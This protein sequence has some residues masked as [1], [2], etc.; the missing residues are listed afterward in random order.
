M[1]T[2]TQHLRGQIVARCTDCFRDIRAYMLIRKNPTH[3]L[4]SSSTEQGKTDCAGFLFGRLPIHALCSF[5]TYRMWHFGGFSAF[6]GTIQIPIFMAGGCSQQLAEPRLAVHRIRP[7]HRQAKKKHVKI[8][9]ATICKNSARRIL[10]FD[11]GLNRYFIEKTLNLRM[12]TYWAGD[13]DVC[14]SRK[15]SPTVRGYA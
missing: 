2:A 4:V 14:H 11:L 9:Y 5:S 15:C 13:H 10:A 1:L 7:L 8:V 6:A 3:G 12:H